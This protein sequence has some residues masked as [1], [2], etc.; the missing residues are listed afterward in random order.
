MGDVIGGIPSVAQLELGAGR[1][2]SQLPPAA[3]G[4]AQLQAT[5]LTSKAQFGPHQQS[6]LEMLAR[7]KF[8]GA[9]AA[10]IVA[11]VRFL[12]LKQSA[13]GSLARLNIGGPG[14][15]PFQQQL[16]AGVSLKG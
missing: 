3:R 5:V 10:R 14:L 1:L 15:T 12:A 8:P 6:E 4:W 2:F 13:G 7:L 9:D 11:I 16:V